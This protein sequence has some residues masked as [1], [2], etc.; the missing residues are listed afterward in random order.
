M[1][2]FTGQVGLVTG[3]SSGIGKATARMMAARGAHVILAARR[4]ELCEEI[5][6]DIRRDG[7]EATVLAC[8]IAD[9]S[10]IDA[11][12]AQIRRDI[13]RL[14]LAFNNAGVSSTLLPLA[15]LDLGDLHQSIQVNVVG[16]LLCMRHELDLM[17][18]GGSGAIV[19]NSSMAGMVG[20]AGLA[21]YST[22]K[23]GVVGLTKATAREYA[24]SNIRINVICP[25]PVLTEMVTST[26]AS[27]PRDAP[28]P[29]FPRLPMG[30][31]GHVDEVAEATCFLLSKAASFI[32]G[33]VLPIDGGESCG[34]G[35]PMATGEA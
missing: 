28:R 33:A 26:I 30:R 17:V 5:A 4:A 2:S 21:V 6:E 9:E 14:D 13:G 19:N 27:A 3:A 16:T 18:S 15:K 12:F 11:L 20:Y 31:M 24:K 34:L 23:H 32:T 25:G 29:V 1:H 22:A 7:G 10:S 35:D 8:D